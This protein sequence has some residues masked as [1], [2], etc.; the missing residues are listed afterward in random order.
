MLLVK[1]NK[2]IIISKLLER[3][4][5]MESRERIVL[6]LPF[7]CKVKRVEFY[8]SETPTKSSGAGEFLSGTPFN[9]MFSFSTYENYTNKVCEKS[10]YTY[11]KE[12]FDYLPRLIDKLINIIE[13]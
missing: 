12:F 2:E 10:S 7:G 13:K 1:E 5:E 4:S 11:K 9:Y 8:M 3:I 6:K